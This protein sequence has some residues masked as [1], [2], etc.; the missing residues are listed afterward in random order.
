MGEIWLPID[1]TN[2]FLIEHSMELYG[3]NSNTQFVEFRNNPIS[4]LIEFN[5]D[6]CDE[7]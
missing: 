5:L 4:S 6:L 7:T 2:Q 1:D 3:K